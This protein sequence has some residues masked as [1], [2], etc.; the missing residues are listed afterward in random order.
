MNK[1]FVILDIYNLLIKREPFNVDSISKKYSVSRRT[2]M[3]YV[4]LVRGFV[5]EYYSGYDVIFDK[6][7]KTYR[8]VQDDSE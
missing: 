5:N 8:L 4:R 3:R 7:S 6:I 2:T 1:S